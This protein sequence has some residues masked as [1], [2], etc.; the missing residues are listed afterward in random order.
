MIEYLH[1]HSIVYRDL[2]PDNIMIDHTGYCKL[3]DMS[4]VKILLKRP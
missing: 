4:T 3:L 1:K 2:K